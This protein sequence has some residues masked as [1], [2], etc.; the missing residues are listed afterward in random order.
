M[1][2]ST[3]NLCDT[4]DAGQLCSLLPA[5]VPCSCPLEA[6]TYENPEAYVTFDAEWL[7]ET[8]GEVSKRCVN[9]LKIL[10]SLFNDFNYR[11]TSLN[12]RVIT[13]LKQN[14]LLTSEPQMKWLWV[15]FK[16]TIPWLLLL[17]ML[18]HNFNLT[19]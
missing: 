17:K 14:L 3:V 8:A 11:F 10:L 16:L 15:A 9:F 13:P 7:G 12:F 2:H 1:P 18:L 5:D 4:L 6:R 19:V